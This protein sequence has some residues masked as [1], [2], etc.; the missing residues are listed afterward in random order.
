MPAAGQQRLEGK[1]TATG[2]AHRG[3]FHLYSRTENINRRT[4]RRQ[5]HPHRREG[6]PGKRMRCGY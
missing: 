3:Q 5:K 2:G 1:K 4:P 6:C